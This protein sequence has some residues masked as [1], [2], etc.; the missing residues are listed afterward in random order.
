M[1]KIEKAAA[2][3]ALFI[4]SLSSGVVLA[5]KLDE[6]ISPVS[7]P[8]TFEDP[9]HSTELRPIFVYHKI[10]NDFITQ[11]GEV[12]VYA[13]QAR[14]QITDELSLIATKDG[15]VRMQPDTAVDDETGLADLGVGA[16]YTL[17]RNHNSIVTG[18]LR[19][20]IPSGARKIFQGYGDGAINPFVSAGWTLCGFSV[21][22]GTGIRQALDSTDSSTWDADIHFDYKIGNFYPLVEFGLNHPYHSGDR[23]PIADEGED[24][25]NFGSTQSAGTNLVTMSAGARYRIDDYIDLGAAYQFPLNNG[26]GTNIIE[27]RLTTDLIVRF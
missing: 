17:Y 8:V 10:G 4:V 11:G 9:R 13:L 16:K 3:V 18:G 27:W 20:E 5:D 23:L 1:I 19:Y 2:L 12:Q 15:I 26:E 22:A 21:I 6:M 24:F 25:F 14:F 7:H